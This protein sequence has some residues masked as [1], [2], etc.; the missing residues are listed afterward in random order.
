[1]SIVSSQ[2]QPTGRWADACRARFCGL[3]GL[4]A[5][6]VSCAADVFVSVSPDGTPRYSTQTLDTN[7]LAGSETPAASQSTGLGTHVRPS[8]LLAI[9]QRVADRHGVSPSLVE[10]IV[11]VESGM[12]PGTVS[13]RGA[14][15]AMQLMSATAARYGHSVAGAWRAPESSIDAGVR[16]LMDLLAQHQGKVALSLAAYNAGTGAFARHR[17][18]TPPYRETMLSV[19]TV[20]ARAVTSP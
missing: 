1:M 8:R 7:A 16:H 2:L 19:P 14:Q 3:A 10:A 18:R 9:S 4:A 12:D 13:A 11:A 6:G 17:G 5:A 20:L 15:G